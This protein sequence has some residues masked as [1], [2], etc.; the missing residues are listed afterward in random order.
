MS[1]VSIAILKTRETGKGGLWAV[2]FTGL[3]VLFLLA[4]A[5]S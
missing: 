4:G 1:L 5:V 2:G 3:S